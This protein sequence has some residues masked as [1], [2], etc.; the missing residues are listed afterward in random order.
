MD[1][2]QKD[3]ES[4]FGNAAS[5]EAVA[6]YG[7]SD[8]AAILNLLHS[9]YTVYRLDDPRCDVRALLAAAP[10]SE[11]FLRAAKKGDRGTAKAVAE[12]APKEW[13]WNQFDNISGR[14][15][16]I[17]NG[18]AGGAKFMLSPFDGSLARTRHSLGREWYLY[19]DDESYCL[20]GQIGTTAN[21][22]HQ[23]TVWIFPQCKVILYV[24]NG[25]ELDHILNVTATI[26]G[27]C[28]ERK[29]EVGRY[30]MSE[31]R[32][33]AICDFWCPHL[34]HYLWNLLSGW[35]NLFS[36]APLDGIDRFLIFRD[37]DFFG[38]LTQLFPEEMR[39]ARIDTVQ[40]DDEVFDFILR[41]NLLIFSVRDENISVE[42]T[43]RIVRHAYSVCSDTFLQR[44]RDMRIKASP[45]MLITIRLDNRSW[46]EQLTGWVHVFRQLHKKYPN[47][48]LIIHGLSGDSAKG[49]TTTWMSVDAE[50]AVANYIEH[51]LSKQMPVINIVGQRFAESIV[52]SDLTDAFVA[53]SGSGMALYKWITNKPGVAFSNRV[54]LD[55]KRPFV[56]I[57]VFDKFRPGITPARYI[58]ADCVRDIEDNNH[59]IPHRNNFSMNWRDLLAAVDAMLTELFP[60]AGAS[61]TSG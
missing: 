41:D 5:Q 28:L 52:L 53:P 38:S 33:V 1:R 24:I 59:G 14:T 29:D 56:A 21:H 9:S 48:G 8:Q 32:S 51:K 25:F 16:D 26:I 19:R 10:I 55:T 58:S 4:L 39:Q 23:E 45:L 60:A 44:A 3:I 12:L 36:V 18:L 47:I 43:D 20:M 11:T 42:L 30:I 22:V 27:K 34:G 40:N 31:T 57:R 54:V 46:R 13:G 2:I 6:R 50:L 61:N 7:A 37:Q 35:A 15:K 17:A 49:W